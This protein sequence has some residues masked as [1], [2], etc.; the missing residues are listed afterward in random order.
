MSTRLRVGVAAVAIALATGCV[1]GNAF[2]QGNAASKAGDLDQAVAYYRTASQAAPDNPNFKI[3]LQ[4]AQLSASRAH[5]ERARAF[6]DADQLEAARGEY[7]LASEYDVANRQ[8]AAKVAAL[9]Q[10]IRAR[11][12]A[13]RPRPPIERMRERARA[14]SAEPL[15]NPASREPLRLSFRN[16]NIRDILDAL[17]NT[18]GI[19]VAYDP[20]VPQ[21]AATVQLDGVTLEQSL[22]QIM[23]VNQL[24]YKVT[25][26][27]AIL[28]FPDNAQKHAQY[29][30]QVV[31]TFYVSHADVTELTQLLSSLIRLPSMAVQPAIQFNKAANTITVRGT[32]SVVQIIEKVI[33]QNDKARAEIM[34]DIEILEVNRIRAKQ[35]GLNLSEYALGG[36]LS[37]EVSAGGAPTVTG[38]PATGTG[39][40]ITTTATGGSS[41]GPS[42]ISSPPAFNLNTISRGFTT[43]D[44]YL[45]VPTAIVRALESDTQTKLVARP[46]LRGAEGNKLTLNLGDEIPIVSTS[47]TPIATGGVGVNPLNSFQLKPVGINIDV[48]PIRVTLDGDI[49]MDLNVESSS[50]GSDVNVAGTNYPSFGSRKVG[51]R[52]RLRDGESNLL[53]GLLREDERKSLNGFPGAVRVPILKQL[54]SNNDETVGSTDIVMLLTPHILRA[55]EI[56]EADLRPIYIGSQGNLGLNGPPPLI[57]APSLAPAEAGVTTPNASVPRSP[58]SAPGATPTAQPGPPAGT[59]F[60]VPA[61]TTPVPGTVL[62]QTPAPVTPAPQTQAVPEPSTA[63]PDQA[64]PVVAAPSAP[65][66]PGFGVAQ[67]ILTPPGATFRVGAGPYTV[68]ISVTN[69][70][71]LSMVALTLTFDPA[72]LRVRAVNEGSFMRSGG[73]SA[74][75]TQQSV[76]GRVDITISRASDTT[77]A[78]G[79]GLLGAV[80]FDAVAPGSATMSVSGTATGPGGTPMGLQFRPVTVS[81]QP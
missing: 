22:Q 51:T 29:D 44:F 58:A 34:F 77:G 41:T 53:A 48:T 78:T 67:V 66:S 23:S 80:L 25:S 8:A 49:L 5:F 70:S 32:A 4:R 35:Y 6:E 16:A 57:A 69:V 52:L 79:T 10:T 18:S 81:I 33:A 42:G 65:S 37:P 30:E 13:A 11:I 17:G 75:F 28:V 59:T 63:S 1:A 45:A 46:Q 27:R 24:S 14:A 71:R 31:Q 36:V 73:A 20:Q 15:L 39:I 26:E 56:T 40:G 2:R 60:G 61:G 50:R 68:P 54:F 38:T 3:A 76:P 7:G 12:E 74:A 43:A 19:N 9:D 21:T 62:I 55:P 47:Y 64:A 72:L